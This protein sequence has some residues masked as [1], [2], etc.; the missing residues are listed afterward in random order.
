VNTDELADAVFRACPQGRGVRVGF[1]PR[2]RHAYLH[3]NSPMIDATVAALACLN[4][5][6]AHTLVVCGSPARTDAAR[7]GLV[8]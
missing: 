3:A 1:H 5:V 2:H 7:S 8:R 6:P 4:P